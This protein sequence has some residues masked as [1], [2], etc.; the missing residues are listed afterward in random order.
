[1]TT[2]RLTPG[3]FRK[4]EIRQGASLRS[5][6]KTTVYYQLIAHGAGARAFT[7]AERLTSTAEAELLRDTYQTY[8]GIPPAGSVR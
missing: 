8:L 4:M 2:R 3:N 6:H 1:M 5:G 7:V